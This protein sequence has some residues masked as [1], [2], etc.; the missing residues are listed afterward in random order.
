MTTHDLI[1]FGLPIATAFGGFCGFWF[2]T[3]LNRLGRDVGEG[4]I[5]PRGPLPIDLPDEPDLFGSRN[6]GGRP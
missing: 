2:A 5:A 4:E 6:Q 1:C 3:V